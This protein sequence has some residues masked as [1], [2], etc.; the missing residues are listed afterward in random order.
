MFCSRLCVWHT[1]EKH[2][3][4]AKFYIKSKLIVKDNLYARILIIRS[5]NYVLYSFCVIHTNIKINE[6]NVMLEFISCLF[7]LI[8]MQD[9]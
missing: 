6:Q 7:T 8:D 2:R 4:K 5:N 1:L 9:K 3:D